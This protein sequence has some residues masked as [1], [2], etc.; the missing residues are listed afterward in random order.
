MQRTTAQR[1]CCAVIG[2]VARVQPAKL[3]QGLARVV[4]ALGVRIAEDTPVTAYAPGTVET[5]RGTVTAPV[6][7]RCTEGFTAGLPPE[8]L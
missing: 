5:P 8:I 6:I 7:L 2:G 1:R 4:A 3:V